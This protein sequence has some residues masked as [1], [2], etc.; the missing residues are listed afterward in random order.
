MGSVD[1]LRGVVRSFTG[2]NDDDY[3]EYEGV[4]DNG[5]A[6]GDVYG[7]VNMTSTAP[8]Y[9]G[10]Y[11]QQAPI[12]T[13]VPNAVVSKIVLIRPEKAESVRE[14]ADYLLKDQA[15]VMSLTHTDQAL[16]NRWLDYLAGVTYAIGGD[17]GRM[18]P[19]TYLLVPK[20]VSLTGFEDVRRFKAE[21][22]EQHD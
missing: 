7:G 16:A 5:G 8:D 14:V 10:T 11:Q 19:Y 12:P 6:Q 17:M 20:N 13:V 2:E 3:Y 9:R 4:Q 18:A 1:R 21:E 22:T 15:V